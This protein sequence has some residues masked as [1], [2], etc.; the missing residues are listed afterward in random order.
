MAVPSPST[1]A[2]EG[3]WQMTAPVDRGNL[4]ESGDDVEVDAVLARMDQL[5]HLVSVATSEEDKQSRQQFSR[6]CRE[7]MDKLWN[8]LPQGIVN[9]LNAMETGEDASGSEIWEPRRAEGQTAKRSSQGEEVVKL[10]RLVFLQSMQLEVKGQRAFAA[11]LQCKAMKDRALTAESYLSS[12]ENELQI[13][14]ELVEE[15]QVEKRSLVLENAMLGAR[16]LEIFHQ[17]K[18]PKPKE[19][20]AEKLHREASELLKKLSRTAPSKP[21]ASI[22]RTASPPRAKEEPT[23][24]SGPVKL[25]VPCG[26]RTVQISSVPSAASGLSGAPMNR[27]HTLCGQI[28]APG[29]W[30]APE[31]RPSYPGVWVP[32]APRSTF[33]RL[34]AMTW[35][36]SPA[37]VGFQLGCQSPVVP[38][39]PPRLPARSVGYPGPVPF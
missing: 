38:V 14:K 12:L 34:S 23:P 26:T 27:R 7:S 1:A 28:Q 22:L 29:A 16:G 10:A 19:L 9:Q 5:M 36:S 17:R 35:P 24:S 21:R 32:P 2:T 15:L 37:S 8:D 30:S 25:G 13:H 3:E 11:E 4:S 20:G 6:M 33:T 39:V 31:P 18:Q